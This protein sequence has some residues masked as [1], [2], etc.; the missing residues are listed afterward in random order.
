LFLESGV[1]QAST[2]VVYCN[3][4]V[5]ATLVYFTAKYL[6][7][8]THFYDGSFEEWTKDDTLPVTEPV[9]FNN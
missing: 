3:T 7:Y 5:W 4:G 6:G 9:K 1:K 2:V 8:E